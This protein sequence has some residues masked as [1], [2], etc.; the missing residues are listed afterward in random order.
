MKLAVLPALMKARDAAAYLGISEGT[1]RTLGIPRR[2]LGALRLYDR[3]DLDSYAASLPYE[4][5][6]REAIECQEADQAFG[7]SR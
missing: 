2:Q 5:Q 4:G 3:N 6:E 1:L 7:V